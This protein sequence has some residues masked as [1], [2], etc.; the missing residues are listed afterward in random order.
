MNCR[1]SKSKP[2]YKL[3]ATGNVTLSFLSLQDRSA[4]E[5]GGRN[6]AKGRE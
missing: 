6:E 1:N 5:W 4:E 3:E 2:I